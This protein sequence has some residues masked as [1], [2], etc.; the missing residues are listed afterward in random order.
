MDV[1]D[2]LTS[3]RCNNIRPM[4]EQVPSTHVDS[5]YQRMLAN[6]ARFRMVLTT[7]Q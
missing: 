2:T 7:D 6:Q 5:A 1:E 4:V 3:P